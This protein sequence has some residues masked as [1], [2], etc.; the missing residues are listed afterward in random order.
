[1]LL[2]E[3]RDEWPLFMTTGKSDVVQSKEIK[4]VREITLQSCSGSIPE[5]KD[6]HQIMMITKI[7]KSE[8]AISDFRL[9]INRGS[10]IT[11]I[12]LGELS[13]RDHSGAD[14]SFWQ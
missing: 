3:R 13:V 2:R 1:M 9:E 4:A 6:L 10:L 5:K 12:V 11:R 7:S 14:P 8:L